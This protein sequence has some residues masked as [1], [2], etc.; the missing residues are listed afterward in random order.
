MT[1]IYGAK[2]SSWP[3]I[4]SY[5][6]RHKRYRF[7][8]QH[9]HLRWILCKR[10]NILCV[11]TLCFKCVGIQNSLKL[12]PHPNSQEG[13]GDSTLLLKENRIY[14][15]LTESIRHSGSQTQQMQNIHIF[16][17]ESLSHPAFL[18]KKIIHI[19]K[20]VSRYVIF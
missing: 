19:R 5:F 7:S 4:P 16:I 12:C 17:Q 1:S 11:L 2:C 20:Y 18:V 8:F 9:S 15:Y 3:T 13:R 14:G 10:E 6:C